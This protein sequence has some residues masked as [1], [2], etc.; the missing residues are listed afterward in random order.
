VNA[1]APASARTARTRER[2]LAAALDLFSRN[3]YDGTTVAQVAAAAGVTEMTFYRHFG[4][5]E[6]LLLD[7]PYDPL[8]ARAVGEQPAGLPALVRVVRGVRTAWERFPIEAAAPV[9]ERVRIVAGSAGLR[10]AMQENTR[11]SQEA[12]AE[13]LV[14]DGTD[15][16]TAAVAAAAVMAALM[17]G[18]VAWAQTEDDDLGAAVVGALDVLDVLDVLD[19]T[20]SSRRGGGSR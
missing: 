18:L 19:P 10:G 14:S 1:S 2:L 7:D 12:I 13:Q 8:M 17:T 9:R 11:R 4:S 3:G 16:T 15:P 5:K 20:Q 6:A